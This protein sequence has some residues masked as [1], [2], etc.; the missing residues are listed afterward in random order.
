MLAVSTVLGAVGA[1]AIEPAA[2]RPAAAAEQDAQARPRLLEAHRTTVANLRDAAREGA[3][4]DQVR[5]A[6]ADARQGLEV[7]ADAPSAPI[8]DALRK[9]LRTSASNLA[10]LAGEPAQSVALSV[11][12]VLVLLERVRP[13]IAGDVGPGLT[14]EGSYSQSK[15]KEPVYGGHASSMGPAPAPTSSADDAAPV[16]VVFEEGARLTARSLLRRP[17]EGSHPRVRLRRRRALRLRRR[18]TAR[19]LPGH[20]RPS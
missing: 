10:G 13:Y 9:E 18:R 17:D 16:P 12:P 15:P 1:L 3:Q 19:H 11:Q 20:R 7:L 4:A 6:L 8:P 5:R 2:M 14:F